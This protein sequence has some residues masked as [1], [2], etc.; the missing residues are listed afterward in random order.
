MRV[1]ADDAPIDPQPRRA[2]TAPW[3]QREVR[4]PA[5]GRAPSRRGSPEDVEASTRGL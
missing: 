2:G 1:N 5:R 3:R 4:L